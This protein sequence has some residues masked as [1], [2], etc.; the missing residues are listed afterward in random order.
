MTGI[1]YDGI[2]WHGESAINRE[3]RKYKTCKE[4]GIRLFRIREGSFSGFKDNADRTWYVSNKRDYFELNYHIFDILRFL[5]FYSKDLPSIDV[6]RDKNEIL[7]YKTV[8]YKDSLAS[9]YPNIAKEWHPSKNGKLIPDDFI[10]GASDR[11]WWLC[12]I[13]G[14]EWESSIVNRTKGHGCDVCATGRRK[15]TKRETLIRK[16]GSIKKELCWLD[17]DYETN[18]HGP[19]YYTSGSGEVV[20]WTRHVCGHRWKTAICSRTRDNKDGCPLCSGK[21]IV[22]G[23]NDL[24]TKRPDLLKEWDYRENVDIDPTMVGIGSH[25]YAKWICNKCGY[26]WE[27]QIYNRTNG[28]GCPCC[29]NKAVVPGINDLTSTEPEIA[30]EWHPLKNGDLKPTEVTRGQAIKVWWLCSKCKNEWQ[31]TINHRCSSK[32]GCSV[33]KRE[34]RKRLK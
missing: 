34:K 3:V 8:R 10:P 16:R 33:C 23:K 20:G 5:T 21:V 13:C 1:E 32:R 29:N 11:V 15:N 30:K 9:H 31:D 26:K 2:F 27:V 22:S 25:R 6:E 18:E 14:N 19:E 17:W 24:A 28:R 12:P 7:E 4:K